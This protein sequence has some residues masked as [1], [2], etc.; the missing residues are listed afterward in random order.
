[1]IRV[2]GDVDD[3]LTTAAWLTAPKRLLEQR[4]PVEALRDGETDVVLG[5]AADYL[6]RSS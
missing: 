4:T 6:A 5:A 1:M 2:L 3:P